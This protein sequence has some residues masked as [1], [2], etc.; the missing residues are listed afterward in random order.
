VKRIG[1]LLK[2]YLAQRGWLEGDPYS[3]LFSG[4]KTIAGEALA[5]HCRIADAKDG[6]LLLEVDH[7]GWMQM[8]QLN[9]PSLLS[10]ARKA[11]PRARI[12]NIKV[13][14]VPGA[15]LPANPGGGTS[16]DGATSR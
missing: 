10:A 14:F 1:E 5:D 16:Q 13:R 12:E 3:P 9:K 6:T 7:P 11:A 4:W 15:G 8:V 2:E